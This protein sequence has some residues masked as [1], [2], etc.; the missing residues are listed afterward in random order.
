MDT[1]ILNVGGTIF[2]ISWKLLKS[3]PGTKLAELSENCPEFRKEKN[4]YYFDRN[5]EIFN[6]ILDFYRYGELHFPSNLCTRL[7]QKELIFWNIESSIESCCMHPYLKFESQVKL[8]DKINESKSTCQECFDTLPRGLRFRRTIWTIM[9]EPLSSK[10][11][12]VYMV[13]YFMVILISTVV[14]LLSSH[15]DFREERREFN[16]NSTEMRI[17][18]QVQHVNEKVITFVLNR[19]FLV[20]VILER[21]TD[22]F[23]V[24]E[25]AVRFSVC[26]CK[27]TFFKSLLNV[28]DLIINIAIIAKFVLENY[29]I[30]IYKSRSLYIIYACC[31]AVVIFRLTRVFRFALQFSGI[32]ILFLALWDSLKDLSMLLLMCLT[33]AIIFANMIFYAEFSNFTFSNMFQGIWFAIVT[34][35]T[36]G[37]GDIYPVT[38]LGCTVGAFCALSGIIILAVPIAIVAGNFTTYYKKYT[39]FQMIKGMQDDRPLTRSQISI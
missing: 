2:E 6:V 21:M 11:A 33:L 1:V 37:Y 29:Y 28:L 26:P 15:A 14:I 22:L 18:L 19:P 30:A 36:V 39:E 3:Y 16:G 8:L 23:F 5:P 24:V 31:H 27:K 17:Y 12:K 32:R 4:E 35:T 10:A 25:M 7:L 38:T 9:E 34:M 20:L 13:F